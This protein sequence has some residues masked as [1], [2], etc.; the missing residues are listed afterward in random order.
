MMSLKYY[1]TTFLLTVPFF[2][3]FCADVDMS[4]LSSLLFVFCVFFSLS[5]FVCFLF[6]FITV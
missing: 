3:S 1:I 4:L 6:L 5:F 2:K